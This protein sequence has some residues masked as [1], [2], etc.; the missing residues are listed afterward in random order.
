MTLRRELME[1]IEGK[2]A[3]SI[4]SDLEWPA[5]AGS[6][7]LIEPQSKARIFR[8]DADLYESNPAEKADRDYWRR[9]QTRYLAERLEDT[10]WAGLTDQMPEN[11]TIVSISLTH[12]KDAIFLS[13]GRAEQRPTV[14]RLPISRTSRKENNS[15]MTD[16]SFEAAKKEL[17]NI[18]ELSCQ[19]GKRAPQVAN[20]GK[21]ARAKWWSERKHLD[22]RL[23]NLLENIEFCWLG[24]FK[25]GLAIEIESLLLSFTTPGSSRRA[26]SCAPESIKSIL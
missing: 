10:R 6:Q 9:V 14:F 25:V 7:D 26:T 20:Q 17:D 23:R 1:N 12:T 21:E 24:A 13:R 5:C 2:L 4:N 15:L 16:L 11:W 19:S 3:V 18:I 22:E 8:L